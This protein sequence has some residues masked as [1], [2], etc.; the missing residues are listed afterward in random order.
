MKPQPQTAIR[1]SARAEVYGVRGGA[2]RRLT[3]LREASRSVRFV[4]STVRAC[5][6]AFVGFGLAA[7][8]LGPILPGVRDD[9]GVG[10]VGTGLAIAAAGAGWGSGVLTSSRV[11]RARGRRTSFAS[12]TTLI[13]LGLL[14]LAAAPVGGVVIASSFVFSFGGGLL[15][16]AANSALAEA[17]DHSLAVANGFFGVGAVAGPLL[18]SALVGIGPGWR[19]A[20]AFAAVFCAFTIPLARSL[21]AGRSRR[22][23]NATAPAGCFAG[24][25]TCCSWR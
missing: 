21:P 1:R 15:T 12:G 18:A 4:P 24:G 5:S 10:D 8:S 19:A 6:I 22:A 25:C 2:R 20:P 3:R 7:A 14:L 13:T 17:D 23:P 16:G 11:S 9:L